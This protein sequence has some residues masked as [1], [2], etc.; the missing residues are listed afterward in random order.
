[1][2][3]LIEKLCHAILD[4]GQCGGEHYSDPGPKPAIQVYRNLDLDPYGFEFSSNG[5]RDPDS[6]PNLEKLTIPRSLTKHS[7]D[8]NQNA[9]NNK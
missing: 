5:V 2:I 9:K 6:D 1:M 7:L 4:K 8:S 3:V